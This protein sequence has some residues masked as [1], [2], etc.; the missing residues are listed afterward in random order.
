MELMK[1]EPSNVVELV[2][3]LYPHLKDVKNEEILKGI[4]LAKALGLNPLKKECHF[5]PYSGSVQIVV[6]YTEYIKRAGQKLNG[7]EVNIGKD[8]I[9]TYAEC[10]IYRKDWEYPFKW[11]VYLNEVKKNTKIW[12]EQPLFM[13]KKTAIAQAFRLCFPE[14]TA[15]LPYSQEEMGY[16]E[17]QPIQTHN[18]DIENEIQKQIDSAIDDDEPF[19]VKPIE[20]K[21]TENQVKKINVM[22]SHK[23]IKGDERH[24]A[25]S[26]IIGR[27]IHSLNDLTKNEAH[28]VIE[29]LNKEA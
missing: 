26:N 20:D 14:E 5:V 9:G 16:T 15:L 6:S 21:A 22:L 12:N 13:L 3:V 17:T 29:H 24:T 1:Q 10:I 28:I 2:R 27:E 7:Y 11:R 25:V 4:A 23:G 19:E 8:E 18:D